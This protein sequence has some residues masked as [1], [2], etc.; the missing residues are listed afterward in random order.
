[1]GAKFAPSLANIFMSEWED[2][3]IYGSR[4]KELLFLPTLHR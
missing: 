1:M 4:G 2:K 3:W